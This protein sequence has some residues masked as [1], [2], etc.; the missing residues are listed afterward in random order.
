[1]FFIEENRLDACMRDGNHT[2]CELAGGAPLKRVF[3]LLGYKV[4]YA[5]PVWLRLV[6][7]RLLL[8]LH[9]SDQLLTAF[10]GFYV[11]LSNCC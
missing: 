6:D 1:M 4:R 7:L 3:Q 11:S 10:V 9:A 8:Q 2:F 5:I